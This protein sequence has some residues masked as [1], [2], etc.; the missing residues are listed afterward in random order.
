LT[1]DT[2]SIALNPGT[3]IINIVAADGKRALIQ[4]AYRLVTAGGV[5]GGTLVD[6]RIVTQTPTYGKYLIVWEDSEQGG[7][8]DQDV[9]GTLEYFVNGN[10]LKVKTYVFAA[11][12]ANPQ[13]F[14]YITSGTSQSGPHFHSGIIGFDY[15][16]PT[17]PNVTGTIP[18]KLNL[19][20][21]CLNCQNQ[22]PPT[23]ATYTIT[24][25]NLGALPDP[26][27]L[28]AKWGGFKDDPDNLTRV[29]GPSSRW[30]V[31]K[32]NG[33]VG[34]D[35]VPDNYYVVYRP[36]LLEAALRNVFGKIADNSN[37][38]P[39]VSLPA[40]AD[41][42]NTATIPAFSYKVTYSSETLSSQLKS[43][44]QTGTNTFSNTESYSAGGKLTTILPSQRNIITN[45]GASG[46]QFTTTQIITQTGGNGY[47]SMLSG[48]TTSTFTENLIN[49]LRG[50]RENEVPK[51]PFRKRPVDTILGPIINSNPWIQR[52]P[53]AALFGK[54]N[55]GY[56]EFASA[57]LNRPKLIWVGANDGMLHGFKA[58]N[59]DPVLSYVPE[60]IIA[61]IN[62]YSNSAT[63][64]ITALMDGNV[65]T[66][67]VFVG[68]NPTETPTFA[69]WKTYLISSLGRGAKGIFALDV[70]DPSAL[71]QANAGAI[72]KWQFTSADDAD[73]GYVISDGGINPDSGQA[74]N[75]VRMPNNK[76]AY[77]AGNGIDSTNGKAVLYIVYVDGP[78]K[79]IAANTYDWTGK[80]EKIILDNGVGN[81]L[82]QPFW[83]D[84]DDDGV[85]D[86]IYA[87]DLKG[88]MWKVNVKDKNPSNWL[89]AFGANKPLYSAKAND[90]TTP[91]P[92]TG[93]P[94]LAFHPEGG[95]VIVFA[96][97]KSIF[98][99]DFPNT[100]LQQRVY[101]IWDKVEY[102]TTTIPNITG[103]TDLEQ[104]V[105]TFDAA[106]N[107][108]QTNPTAINWGDKA[109]WYAN[110]PYTSGMVIRNILFAQDGST[111]IGV[112][113]IFP[114]I[115]NI[116]AANEA[117][118]NGVYGA[119]IQIDAITGSQKSDSFGAGGQIGFATTDQN[120]SIVRNN[121]SGLGQ[122][123]LG[124]S[125]TK[126]TA[127]R[128]K[129]TTRLY[130]REIP[131]VR[132]FVPPDS[133]R[134]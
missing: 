20:G 54:Y 69:D 100:A 108:F 65:A 36:D 47:L 29:P 134:Q 91:L 35:G 127:P 58:D 39:A 38:S 117:C 31:E 80:Y 63:T 128:K 103:L 94:A 101:A 45:V 125:G 18:T 44:I 14:G 70:T 1:V 78:S 16:D 119:Y 82:M 64:S 129:E 130:W 74:A 26:L 115:G 79:N 33:T 104:Q 49:Y 3:P 11:A 81:G 7:D 13:G 120:F 6:F 41:P 72:F 62:K 106:G 17:N 95:R 50:D 43:Y 123:I 25:G 28:A 99:S 110:I 105:W 4:P 113:V 133:D 121:S 88:N 52:N 61:N 114:T 48:T 71:T 21:G 132:T 112:P 27:L 98:T 109:G 126:S 131:G 15:V 56:S 8:Y 96:T 107:P 12:T 87:G 118:E 22:D 32:Q 42:S 111:D 86:A 55:V 9:T 89:P 23:T 5:G 10:E 53:S 73:L 34:A 40:L 68:V 59:L 124:N 46:E 67:D 24:G 90:G 84:T 83:V 30:D 66:S 57:Q 51:G 75:V 97:G 76:Y 2:Y 37:A 116:N 60:P 93:A 92:I 19:S 122:T 102:G 77:I 85:V